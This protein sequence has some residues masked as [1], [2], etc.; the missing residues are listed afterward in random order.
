MSRDWRLV[1]LEGAALPEMKTALRNAGL[2]A[3]DLREEIT[4]F[5][6]FESTAGP[7]GWAALEP[8]GP[9][10]LLRSVLVLPQ[11]RGSGTGSEMLH[12]VLAAAAGM[13]TRRLWLLTET[14]APF[15]EKHG[16]RRAERSEAP[17]SIAATTEFR[18]TCPA[19]AVCMTRSLSRP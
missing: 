13:G 15:F 5:F 7:A 6:R 9:D 1:R 10:A 18:E 3:D 8:Y 12:Q 11:H 4:A 16:F 2:P 19:S 14:A 17:A